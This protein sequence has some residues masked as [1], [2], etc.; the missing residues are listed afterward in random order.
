M[1]RPVPIADMLV[2]DPAAQRVVEAAYPA[3]L[4][5]QVNAEL[6]AA[7]AS[8]N[9]WNMV[10]SWTISGGGGGRPWRAS[11]QLG[12]GVDWGLNTSLPCSVARFRC[13]QAAH[14]Q[15]VRTVAAQMLTEIQ[16]ESATAHV[17]QVQVAESRDGSCLVGILYSTG[18][19]GVPT[20]HVEAMP[21]QGV[22]VATVILALTIPRTLTGTTETQRTY[23]IDYAIEIEDITG[24]A[25]ISA[26]FRMDGA[27]IFRTSFAAPAGEWHTFSGHYYHVQSILAPSLFELVIA[28]VGANVAGRAATMTATLI[29]NANSGG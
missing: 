14:A 11:M 24:M 21:P 5:S 20:Y 3:D 13:R 28:P 19:G 9:F 25:G 8:G 2:L 23:L 4:E 17:W 7:A 6:A 10:Q 29:H 18:Q 16:I 12:I 22:G 27:Q 1:H 26:Y 15:E